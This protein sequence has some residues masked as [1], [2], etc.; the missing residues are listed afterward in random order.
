MKKI[1]QRGQEMFKNYEKMKKR[2]FYTVLYILQV[3][4]R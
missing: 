1:R 2:R 3:F 4:E